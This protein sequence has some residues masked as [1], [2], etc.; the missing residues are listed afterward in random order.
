MATSASLILEDVPI[1]SDFYKTVLENLKSSMDIPDNQIFQANSNNSTQKKIDTLI[2]NRAEI[3]LAIIDLRLRNLKT[4]KVENGLDS[5]IYLRRVS[6]RTKIVVI[7]CIAND[8]TY[9]KVFSSCQPEGFIIKDEILNAEYLENALQQ[10]L[11]GSF[12]FSMT[13]LDFLRKQA[14]GQLSL[15]QTERKIL[16]LMEEGYKMTDIANKLAMS[17]SVVEKRKLNIFKKLNVN[18]N[19]KDT[20]LKEAHKKFII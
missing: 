16:K 2:K 17:V 8:Y 6:P 10:L 19:E 12:F 11:S 5:A 4:K 9:S 7:T 15:D 13:V 18:S 20:L 1:I 14:L 3:A